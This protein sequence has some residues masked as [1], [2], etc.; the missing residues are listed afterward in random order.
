[1]L[2]QDE[3]SLYRQPSQ[4]W[5]WAS[6]GRRQPRISFAA[7]GNTRTRVIG[8][9]NAITGAVHHQQTWVVDRRTYGRFVL[10]AAKH[11]PAATKIYVIGDNWPVHTHPDAQALL[12]QDPRIEWVSLPTYAPWLNP[13]EK[14]WRWLRQTLVHA[15]PYADDFHLFKQRI[16]ETLDWLAHDPELI[17]RYTGLMD[18]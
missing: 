16:T 3:C 15:H 1:M 11:Y 2:Y 14:V 18:E 17:L 6:M 12:A 5:L 7:K 9:L 4:G 13:I 8:A 10:A